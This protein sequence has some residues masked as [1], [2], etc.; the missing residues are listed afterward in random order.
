[1]T[2]RAAFFQFLNKDGK[3]DRYN[4]KGDIK[5]P[6]V[7]K[8]A[9]AEPFTIGSTAS[10]VLTANGSPT[11]SSTSPNGET[12]WTYSLNN[13]GS[14]VDSRVFRLVSYHSTVNFDSNGLVIGYVNEG[15]L[16]VSLGQ[17]DPSAQPLKL[18]PTKEDMVKS[19]GT[20][21]AVVGD[22]WYYAK[23]DNY[24]ETTVQFDK[25]GKVEFYNNGNYNDY[26]TSKG[27]LI[28]KL[29]EV[30][31]SATFKLG[32][33]AE[34]IIRANGTPHSIEPR[35]THYSI[36]KYENVAGKQSTIMMDSN[37]KVVAYDNAGNLNV[38]FGEKDPSAPELQKGASREDVIK[39]LGTPTGVPSINTWYYGN[40]TIDFR[41]D[42]VMGY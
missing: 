23:P 28:V 6:E 42:K 10:K 41:D 11:G 1:M 14:P 18:G 7:K 2:T 4:N 38:F 33:T 3:V 36:W 17:K 25:D 27:T 24:D 40:R 30:I 9:N 37:D 19:N 8:A 15:N 34:E 5:I 21:L 13:A 32:S 20:P 29:G 26:T 16:N 12:T 31:P 35:H 39:A 22:V